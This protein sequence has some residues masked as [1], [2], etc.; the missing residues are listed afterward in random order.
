MTNNTAPKLPEFEIKDYSNIP[1]RKKFYPAS[2]KADS[3]VC[4]CKS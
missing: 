3:I 1:Q 4:Y 2:E